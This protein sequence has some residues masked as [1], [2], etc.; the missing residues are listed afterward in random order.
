[1]EQEAT[2]KAGRRKGYPSLLSRTRGLLRRL[3][4]Q[5]RKSL[6]QHFLIDQGVLKTIVQ[7]AGL[8]PDDVVI[9]IGP[10]LG[11]L[12]T[13]LAGQAGWVVAVELDGR[14]AAALKRTLASVDNVTIINGDI[15]RVDPV[16]LLEEPRT[17]LPQATE[18]GSPSYKV[19]ANLPY[20]ITSA[21]IRRFLEASA[22]PRLMVVMV[23][24]EVA[25]AIVARPG[26]MSLLSVSV[27]FYGEPAIVGYVPAG[28][29]YPPPEVDSAI[30]KIALHPEPVVAVGDSE[31]F[32]G[33]VRAGFAAPRKQI[34]N[35]LAQGLGI[36]KAE[37]LPILA[38]AA[39]VPRRRAETL[40][41]SEWARL[42]QVFSQV[43]QPSC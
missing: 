36:S 4:L 41:L 7:A 25:E 42:W 35:S 33:L 23:Q 21:V 8:T 29:F 30:L 9:E 38:G 20:Y 31:G 14:L 26:R 19:V 22:R 5:A 3:D 15:L 10:G 37:V 27:Q 40:A 6:G 39:I 12:T 28:S 43:R 17:G 16:A 11:V 1:M 18:D 24:K 13:E 34:A 2:R 32:F